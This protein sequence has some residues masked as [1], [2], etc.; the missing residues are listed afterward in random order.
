MKTMN[1]INLKIFYALLLFVSL[2]SCDDKGTQSTTEVQQTPNINI[3]QASPGF[4]PL[5]ARLFD[6]PEDFSTL[7]S[8]G[9]LYFESAQYDEAIQI[10]DKALAVNP[11]CAN[12]LNDRGLALFYTGDPE[13]ALESFDKAIALA[14]GFAHAWLS[15]GFVLVSENR[16]QE[17]IAPLNRVKELDTTGALTIEADKFLTLVAAR[18]LQ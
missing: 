1:M 3:S 18:N 13:S 15:K 4:E 14:P 10:Y 5:K 12:C 7:S 17:A 11:L 9:N 6:N 2:I 16:Y 8:L